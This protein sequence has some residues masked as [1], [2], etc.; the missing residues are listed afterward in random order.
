M[1]KKMSKRQKDIKSKL[2]AAICMLLVSSIMM[3]STTYAWFT[4]STAPEV[5]GITTA[6]GANGNL[7]MALL[8]E[9]GLAD[10]ATDANDFG[11]TSGTSDSMAAQ[12]TTLANVTWGNLVDLG[13]TVNNRNAYGMDNITLYPAALNYVDDAKTQVNTSAYLSTPVYGADGRVSELESGTV[14]GIFDGTNFVQKTADVDNPAGV[15]VIGNV[16]GMSDRQIAYRNALAQA[17]SA[18]A[19]AGQKAGASLNRNGTGLG[20]IVIK[21]ATNV[22]SYDEDDKTVLVNMVS[23][24]EG[25]ADNPGPLADIEKSIR[26]YAYAYEISVNENYATAADG[27]LGTTP[28]ADLTESLSGSAPAVLTTMISELND[29]VS[30]VNSAKSALNALSGGSYTWDQLRNAMSYLLNT[31]LATING[32]ALAGENKATKEQIIS[33]YISQQ[34]LVLV[35]PTGSGV[36]ADIADHV[37]EYTASITIPGDALG[38]DGVNVPCTMQAK[39]TLSGGTYQKQ[40][41]D[42]Y[43]SIN[44]PGMTDT[45]NAPISDYYGYII[46][47]AFKTNASGSYLKLQSDGIDRIYNGEGQQSTTEETMGHGSTMTFSTSSG[48]FTNAQMIALMQNIKVIFFDPATGKIH[49]TAVLD[50]TADNIVYEGNNVTVKMKAEYAGELQDGETDKI[51]DL[52]QNTATR[53]SVLVYLDGENVKNKDVAFD[54]AASMTG[55]INLQ[56]ASSATLVPMDYKDFAA[57][58]GEAGTNNP[59]IPEDT[60]DVNVASVTDGYTVTGNKGAYSATAQTVVVQISGTDGTETVTINDAAATYGNGIW[61]ATLTEEPADLTIVVTPAAGG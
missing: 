54:S 45:A 28:L 33:S 35:L 49:A 24:L 2:M 13:A 47:L 29:T 9:G 34:K 40:A 37:G 20:G 48:T 22:T 6:V 51:M 61:T 55:K 38:Y 39:S 31:D 30:A 26:Q 25:T 36:Y 32:L 27:I 23:G 44:V 17:S 50:T 19:N 59:Q 4:L 18:A 1:N 42:A 52:T 58:A 53:L 8:P 60:T 43:A 57:I 10:T 46:D 12:D 21:Y 16:S 3:V 14:T 7:E 11:I 5:T 41:K 15:R 56:F